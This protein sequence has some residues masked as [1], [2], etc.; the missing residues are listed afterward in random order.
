[1]HSA[2][3]IVMCDFFYGITG[4]HF[5]QNVEMYSNCQCTAIRS[6]CKH[7]CEMSHTVSSMYYGSNRIE[8]PLT[9][10]ISMQ[11]L[12]T[13]PPGRLISHFRDITWHIHSSDLAVPNYFRCGYVRRKEHVLPVPMT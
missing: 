5:F 13:M 2:K 4:H 12:R 11:V 3:V 1:L 7:F 9:Q 8:Q 6:C 10:H